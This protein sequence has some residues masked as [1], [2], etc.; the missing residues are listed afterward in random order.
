MF[1]GAV[2]ESILFM[3]VDGHH[4]PTNLHRRTALTSN[5][6]ANVIPM[7]MIFSA[8]TKAASSRRLHELETDGGNHGACPLSAGP[9]LLFLGS[10]GTRIRIFR[11]TPTIHTNRASECS[12][13]EVQGTEVLL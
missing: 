1:E 8:F 13:D 12:L 10:S 3:A 5:E 11:S 2:H 4:I 7:T 6:T 9:N